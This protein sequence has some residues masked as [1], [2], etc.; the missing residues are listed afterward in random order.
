VNWNSNLADLRSFDWFGQV[1]DWNYPDDSGRILRVRF[2]GE[3]IVRLLDD[4][5]LSTET[6]P[7]ELRGLVPHHFAYLVAGHPFHAAQSEAWK[8]M[9][10]EPEHYQFLTGN[11]CMDVI[12]TSA[13]TF[14]MRMG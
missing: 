2:R 6:K 14:E 7:D 12:S 3:I 11:T 4:F 9:H 13:P 10:R 5:P 1:A 8:A